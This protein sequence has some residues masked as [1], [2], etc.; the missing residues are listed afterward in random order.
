MTAEPENM[1]MS[2]DFYA[3]FPAFFALGTKHTVVPL[4]L[5]YHNVSDFSTSWKTVAR[6]TFDN[7]FLHA[8]NLVCLSINSKWNTNG[9]F[10]KT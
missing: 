9:S 5:S 10:D 6:Y 8:D 7:G 1:T 4:A 3:F 2:Y